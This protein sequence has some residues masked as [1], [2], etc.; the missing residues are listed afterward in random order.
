MKQF[1][2]N[3]YIFYHL[4]RVLDGNNRGIMGYIKKIIAAKEEQDGAVARNRHEFLSTHQLATINV[5]DKLEDTEIFFEEGVPGEP[6]RDFIE[7]HAHKYGGKIPILISHLS[8]RTTGCTHKELY[9]DYPTIIIAHRFIDNYCQT[10]EATKELFLQK[11]LNADSVFF[12]VEE[13]RDALYEYCAEVAPAKLMD[14]QK[15][16]QVFPVPFT[17][18]PKHGVAASLEEADNDIIF[19]GKFSSFRGSDEILPL[20]EAMKKDPY[21]Q[22]RRIHVITM[23]NE[24]NKDEIRALQSRVASER[25]PIKF[26]LNKPDNELEDIFSKHK[27]ARFSGHEGASQRSTTLANLLAFNRICV[28]K[29]TNELNFR[30]YAEYGDMV[31]RANGV[32][33][34]L[35][36]IKVHESNVD[37]D[38]YLERR[39]Q[40]NMHNYTADN[41]WKNLIA[42]LY[43]VGDAAAKSKEIRV[44]QR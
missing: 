35:E 26:H 31:Y 36:A 14:L 39:M 8:I 37:Q 5:A 18:G 13:E 16:T 10:P 17:V 15:K 38:P 22:G 24:E 41:S 11:L 25:L 21:F 44:N 2:D 12:T 29:V 40:E 19:F 42:E 30:P 28:A 4:S 6:I 7:S 9:E 32:A 33:E 1:S 43:N 27:Y 3:K 20:A 23:I 34:T